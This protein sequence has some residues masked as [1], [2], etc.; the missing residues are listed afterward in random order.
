MVLLE[1]RNF[2]LLVRTTGRVTNTQ[3]GLFS[4]K[5]CQE[6]F[7]NVEHKANIAQLISKCEMNS[8]V[9]ESTSWTLDIRNMLQ[10]NLLE[11][12]CG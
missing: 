5:N 2:S 9:L 11:S 1:Q 6:V 7:L 3:D 12:E 4:V 10:L 8:D